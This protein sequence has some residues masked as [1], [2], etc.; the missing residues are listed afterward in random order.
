M[1]ILEGKKA[2]ITGASK[3]IG[4]A[5]AIAF[6]EAG[7]SVGFTYLHSVDKAKE[8]ESELTL[9]GIKAKAYQSNA[10]DFEANQ[11]LMQAFLEDF[12]KVDSLINNAGIT[13]DNFLK[14]MTEQQFDEVITNNL[15]S[16][17]N[18]SKASVGTFMQQRSGTIINIS[19]V[20]GQRGNAVQSNYAASKAGIIGFGKALALELGPRNIRVNTIAPGFIETEM[21]E[22]LNEKVIAE[23][24]KSIP[25]RRAGKASEVADLAV[26]LA[27]DQ[28]TYITGQVLA[29]NGGLY[30]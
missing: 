1:K 18:L 25:L 2:L 4:R 8:L 3:G 30:T 12:G 10:C 6:A 29:I 16:V 22:K 20:V 15:K 9:K 26:F 7:A 19:S 13:R 14:R 17:F 23:W 24:K 21:T 28:S 11:K 27:S 5:I